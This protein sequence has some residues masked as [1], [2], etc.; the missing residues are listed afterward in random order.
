MATDIAQRADS[1]IV[2]NILTQGQCCKTA[3]GIGVWTTSVV[4]I[5]VGGMLIANVLMTSGIAAI[6]H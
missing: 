5:T 4:W 3:G 1:H 6:V 2:A